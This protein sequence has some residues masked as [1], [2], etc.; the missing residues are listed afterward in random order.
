MSKV[1][2]PRARGVPF[3]GLPRE[4]EPSATEVEDAAIGRGDNL[5]GLGQLK[6]RIVD[7]FDC[8]IPSAFGGQVLNN[9]L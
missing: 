6:V 1:Q 4:I 9:L 2:N 3:H 5:L 7:Q 8:P